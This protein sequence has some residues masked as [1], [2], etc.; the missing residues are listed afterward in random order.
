MERATL[1]CLNILKQWILLYHSTT[2]R[3]SEINLYFWTV[4]A[5]V[6]RKV[7]DITIIYSI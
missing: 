1:S 3:C 4:A 2:L 7:E 6:G 5:L